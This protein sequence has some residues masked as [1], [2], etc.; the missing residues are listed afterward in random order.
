MW[1]LPGAGGKLV[2]L[3]ENPQFIISISSFHS[4]SL[5]R[6]TISIYFMNE[7]KKEIYPNLHYI[8]H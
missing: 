7:K 4:K 2:P 8:K 6:E 5:S 3:R 1:M